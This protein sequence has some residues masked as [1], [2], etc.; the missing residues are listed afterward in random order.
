MGGNVDMNEANFNGA[1][2]NFC[3]EYK[4][5][6]WIRLGYMLKPRTR[7]R[8]I[9]VDNFIYIIGGRDK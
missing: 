8:S 3:D 2:I 7:H 9:M 6:R 1:W 5:G 4:N